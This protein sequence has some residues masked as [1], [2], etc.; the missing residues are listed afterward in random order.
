MF[1]QLES[2][3][4]GYIFPLHFV[5]TAPKVLCV[6]RMQSL[7]PQCTEQWYAWVFLWGRFRKPSLETGCSLTI[8]LMPAYN[9]R[10]CAPQFG[11]ESACMCLCLYKFDSVLVTLIGLSGPC[12]WMRVGLWA[13]L[14]SVGWRLSVHTVQQ[15]V[16][17]SPLFLSLSLSQGC[18]VVSAS[19]CQWWTTAGRALTLAGIHKTAFLLIETSSTECWVL[20]SLIVS[21]LY[22]SLYLLCTPNGLIPWLGL[23]LNQWVSKNTQER[24][25][26]SCSLQTEEELTVCAI[27]NVF[28]FFPFPAW[29]ALWKR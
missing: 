23:C 9:E 19:S 21:T 2:W 8:S 1:G 12:V 28:S 7:L 3:N 14:A 10:P 20:L 17:P 6:L 24:T 18:S 11:R 29:R 4:F 13:R 5:S 27:R 26:C 15:P 16:T 22:P 25:S